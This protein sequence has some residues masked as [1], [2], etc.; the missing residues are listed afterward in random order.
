MRRLGVV[1]GLLAVL[2][3]FATTGGLA[4]SA[5]DLRPF[6]GTWSGTMTA[7][8][9]SSDSGPSAAPA[10][11]VL[12]EDGK[13]TL[14][15]QGVASGT[16]CVVCADRTQGGRGRSVTGNNKRDVEIAG[17][18]MSIGQMPIESNHDLA[19]VTLNAGE[20][21]AEE[22][23]VDAPSPRHARSPAQAA[24]GSCLRL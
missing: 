1:V 23:A 17:K 9:S 11:F 19:D 3:A 24:E 14:T 20:R 15:C 13:W 16:A 7:S 22:A 6:A 12:G 8:S 18:G 4:Q 10:R 2:S 21:L 5:D